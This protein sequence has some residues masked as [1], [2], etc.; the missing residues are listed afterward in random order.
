MYTYFIFPFNIPNLFSFPKML[1]LHKGF[2]V[3]ICHVCVRKRDTLRNYITRY[4]TRASLLT[5]QQ[6]GPGHVAGQLTQ[7]TPSN[8]SSIHPISVLPTHLSLR[9]HNAF[10]INLST[11]TL[12]KCFTPH[13]H[14]MLF[15]FNYALQP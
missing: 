12:Y 14:T 2:T 3:M 6:P 7:P 4:G 11:Y 9:A 10:P 1:V 13:I 15:I 5:L 8:S